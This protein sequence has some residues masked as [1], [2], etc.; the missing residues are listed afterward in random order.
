[1]TEILTGRPATLAPNGL[2][3][4]PHSLA[5]SAGVDVLR[6]GGSAIDAALAA[7]AALSVLYPHMTS[8][9]GDAFWLIHDAQDRTGPLHRR[10]R[11]RDVRRH[12]RRLR[13]AAASARCRYRGVLPGTLTVP[14][15]VASWTEAHAAYGRLPLARCLDSAIGYARDGF[16]VTAAAGALA[17]LAR[18]RPGE[19]PGGGGDP[20]EARPGA[21]E[22][23]PRPHAGSDRQRRL[24]RLLRGR[25]RQGAGALVAR[26]TTASSP[27]ADLKAQ[28]ARWGEPIKGTYRDVTIYET[29]PPT[30]GFAVLEM[31]NLLEPFELHQQAVPRPRPRASDGAGQAGRLSRPR[32]AHRPIRA[33]PTCRSS[34]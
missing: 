18:A 17:R 27:P 9:G 30:Q 23:R 29:P 28:T 26:P 32:P 31:L 13:R 4:S 34:G 12:D 14:G 7:S 33:S 2:V 10:R 5:S 11:P 22:P 1:M 15:A 16:P 8:I 19:E 24:V 25:G 21:Q 20:A 3:T 6:A